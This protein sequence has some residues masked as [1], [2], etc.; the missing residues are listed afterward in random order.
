[1]EASCA[2]VLDHYTSVIHAFQFAQS[3]VSPLNGDDEDLLTHPAIGYLLLGHNRPPCSRG[4]SLHLNLTLTQPCSA[5]QKPSS[6][7]WRVDRREILHP[8]F[9]GTSENTQKTNFLEL[10]NGE[11]RGMLLP[12]TSVKFLPE[13]GSRQSSPPKL[14]P[15]G[16]EVE[17]LAFFTVATPPQAGMVGPLRL[18][19]LFVVMLTTLLPSG[20]TIYRSLL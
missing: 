8:N 14:L 16:R 19:T 10:R 6:L 3:S 18:S 17:N 4:V 2:P 13:R 7:P 5:P 15:R 12:R 1:M 20:L 11:V 9:R